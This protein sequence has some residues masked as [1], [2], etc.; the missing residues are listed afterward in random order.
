[1]KRGEEVY[2]EIL[3]STNLQQKLIDQESSSK[4]ES[5]N[6]TLEKKLGDGNIEELHRK[7]SKGDRSPC[8]PSF[9]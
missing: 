6:I 9:N 7:N 5:I 3:E 4:E 1:M 8:L 2:D